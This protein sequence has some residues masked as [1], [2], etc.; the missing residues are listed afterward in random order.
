MY[1]YRIGSLSTEGSKQPVSATALSLNFVVVVVIKKGA[2]ICPNFV[3]KMLD[4]LSYLPVG[5]IYIGIDITTDSSSFLY[6]A[7][8]VHPISIKPE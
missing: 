8:G 1:T 2:R 5:L 6:L 3:S 4:L 7:M